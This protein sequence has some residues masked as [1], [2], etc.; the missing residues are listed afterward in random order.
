MGFVMA[1]GHRVRDARKARDLSQ[2]QL[3]DLVGVNQPVIG[4]IES[5]DSTN[6][7]HAP[8]IAKALRVSLEWLLTGIGV[9]GLTS[10]DEIINV[11]EL[12]DLTSDVDIYDESEPAELNEIE[13]PMYDTVEVSAGNGTII[14]DVVKTKEKLRLPR[15][16]IEKL[17]VTRNRVVGAKLRGDSLESLIQDGSTIAIDLSKADCPIKNNKIYVI[18]VGGEYKAKIL[19]R[20]FNNSSVSIK[21]TNDAYETITMSNEDF[22][23]EVKVIG[24]IFWWS[25]FVKW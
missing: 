1:F 2:Q 24:W 10:L 16:L 3:A 22:D 15:G 19:Q 17:G 23:R 18:Q 14:H 21:S 5:R 8:N 25:N 12:A 4:S 20:S 6:S 11:N 9:S 13:F 7:K